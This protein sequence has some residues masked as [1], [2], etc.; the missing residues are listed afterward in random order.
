M[1]RTLPLRSVNTTVS[2]PPPLVRLG[3]TPCTARCLKLPS[4]QSH[5]TSSGKMFRI[6]R[7]IRIEETMLSFWRFV[8]V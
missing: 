7:Y 3:V 8:K 1:P 5:S 2:R 4:S 6:A